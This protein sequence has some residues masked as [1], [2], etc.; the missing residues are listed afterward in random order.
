[1][2]PAVCGVADADDLV[3]CVDRRRV[4]LGPAERLQVDAPPSLPYEGVNRRAGGRHTRPDDLAAPVDRDRS[5]V[6]AAERADCGHL[7]VLP[8]DDAPL[9]ARSRALA[10][11]LA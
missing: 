10:H 7:A 5:A 8:Q 4:A 9:A 11:D 3:V 2:A 6:S 1:M